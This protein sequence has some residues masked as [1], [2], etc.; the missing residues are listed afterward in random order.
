MTA[1]PYHIISAIDNLIFWPY[2]LLIEI[3]F[4]SSEFMREYNVARGNNVAEI[5]VRVKMA[6]TINYPQAARGLSDNEMALFLFIDY[7]RKSDK[8]S[9]DR[10]GLLPEPTADAVLGRRPKCH[11]LI[12]S[13][14]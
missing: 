4:H 8:S 13:W 12:N 14:L 10:P 6:L 11:P 2:L 1:Q 7:Q 3:R 9:L 5:I